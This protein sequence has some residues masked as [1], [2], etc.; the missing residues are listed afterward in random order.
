MK[1][2]LLIDDA[3]TTHLF[4]RSVLSRMNMQLESSYSPQSVPT[5]TEEDDHGRRP[6]FDLIIVDVTIENTRDGIPLAHQIA[7]TVNTPLVFL[8]ASDDRETMEEISRLTHYGVILKTSSN[9]VIEESVRMAFRLHETHQKQLDQEYRY[10]SLVETIQEIVLIHDQHGV[11]EYINRYGAETLGRPVESIVGAS[12]SDVF[13]QDYLIRS[14]LLTSSRGTEPHR[15]FDMVSTL[16]TG[17]GDRITVGIRSSPV[18]R[19]GTYVGELA[20]ARDISHSEADRA[21]LEQLNRLLLSIRQV[22]TVLIRSTTAAEMAQDVCDVLVSNGAYNAAWIL[23]D[24]AEPD[25][26][27]HAG[28][29]GLVS[30]G[31]ELLRILGDHEPRC[32]A[33]PDD[34]QAQL[35]TCPHPITECPQCPLHSLYGSSGVL[36]LRLHYAGTSYGVFTAAVDQQQFQDTDVRQIFT[37][38]ATDLSYAMYSLTQ[39]FLRDRAEADALAQQRQLRTFSD[40]SPMSIITL[41]RW[42]RV[43]EGNP[44]FHRWTGYPVAELQDTDIHTL[45]REPSPDLDS[46]IPAADDVT[47]EA[48]RNL[49]LS[50]RARDG[51]PVWGEGVIVPIPAESNRDAS[52]IIVLADTTSQ[53][54]AEERLRQAH[55]DLNRSELRYR[56]LF[57]DSADLVFV[58]TAEGTLVEIND[59]GARMLGY[60]SPDHL[61]GRSVVEFYAQRSSRQL[62]LEEM[63]QNG[64]VKNYE[65]VL[66][67][68]TGE[69]LFGSESATVVRDSAPNSSDSDRHHTD[70]GRA[71]SEQLFQG[72][73][74]DITERI[75]S[76]QESIRR[77]ME[78]SKANEELR[79]A[80]NE[81]VKRE[82]LASIGE[83]S[84]GVAHEINN[85]LAFVRSNLSTLKRYVERH[86]TFFTAYRDVPAPRPEPLETLWREQHIEG[87]LA[88]IGDLFRE[89]EDGIQRIVAIVSNL[90]DFS[91]AGHNE[92]MDDYDINRGVES[93][94]TIARNEYK[95]VA[96]VHVERGDVPPLTCNANEINQV[97]LTLI[98]NASQAIK[99][100]GTGWGTITI[101]TWLDGDTVCCSVS[102]TGPGITAAN[103]SKVFEPFFTTKTP[104]EGTGLGLSIAYD[105]IVNRHGGTLRLQSEEGQGAT[106]TLQLPRGGMH[107]G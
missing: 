70:G 24:P 34:P 67:T 16:T 66:R 106:F 87:T 39:K 91:R 6:R 73:I 21:R 15:S 27:R 20:A 12:V 77:S 55:H 78:L 82:K 3:E 83:L 4:M 96:N 42:G 94:L 40:Y 8:T 102:D 41:N 100:G 10:H 59:A 35:Y 93:T 32:A 80:Q 48:S 13:E 46:L 31:T 30:S 101:R 14:R 107:D 76:E 1:R 65:I 97:L 29:A 18:I 71:H 11:V 86:A 60:D 62:F 69:L 17:S 81:L 63:A 85:P 61:I 89:T 79:Q 74:H 2:V 44:F 52:V 23:L 64:F 43:V 105:I 5:L 37:E 68:R 103:Q 53:H 98:V 47:S 26:V 56:S 45:L 58:S 22:H 99:S 90:K 7:N 75:R 95:Y 33:P 28:A 38:L 49:S 25:N 92:I 72:V 19:H 57:R 84:A 36:S 9:F 88:D 104:G 54:V 51:T 50:L